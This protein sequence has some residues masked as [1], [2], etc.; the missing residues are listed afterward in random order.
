MIAPMSWLNRRFTLDL[1]LEW[2]PAVV[3]RLRGTPARA[4][5]LI[6]GA[7]EALLSLRPQGKWSVKDHIGHLHDLCE[8]DEA[9]L[10]A[11]RSDVGVLP[12]A[13]MDNAR[14][15]S[16]DHYLRPTHEVLTGFRTARLELVRDL[17][18][19][20]SEQVST[21]AHHP[22][23]QKPMRVIDW[24]FFVAEHDDHHMAWIRFLLREL[25]EGPNKDRES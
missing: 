10:N 4:E 16:A 17:E 25:A 11:F 1:P 19:L 8:L 13:D 24:A 23:L 5:S 21:V 2:F 7:P 20:T 12:A 6:V 9:R 18:A 14:T 22:R 15:H 3:E